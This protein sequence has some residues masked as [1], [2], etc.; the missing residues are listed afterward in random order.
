MASVKKFDESAVVNQLRH[1]ERTIQNPENKDICKE[2]TVENYS[3]APQRGISSYDYYVERKKEL[4]CYNRKDVKV[5][6]GWIVTVPK[7]LKESDRERF[8]QVTYEFL[9][10]RYGERNCIQ[11]IVHNEKICANDV[12]NKTELRNFHPALQKWLIDHDV[13]ANILTGITKAQGGNRTVQELKNGKT[14]SRWRTEEYESR[15]ERGSRWR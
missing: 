8:F 14:R 12:L 1:I 2:R 13:Q 7:N 15:M 3:L 9:I 11:A 5:M 4:Y 10:E 6:A